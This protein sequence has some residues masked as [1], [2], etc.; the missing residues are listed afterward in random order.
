[1]PGRDAPTGSVPKAQGGAGPFQH[2]RRQPV[3]DGLSAPRTWPLQS[4]AQA[5]APGLTPPS[6]GCGIGAAV[7]PLPSGNGVRGARAESAPPLGKSPRSRHGAPLTSGGNG[8][9]GSRSSS[10]SSSGGGGGSAGSI[11]SQ[12]NCQS[13]STCPL[14]SGSAC[15]PVANFTGWCLFGAGRSG[16]GGGDADS[17]VEEWENTLTWAVVGIVLVSWEL[18]EGS[19][20]AIAKL[21]IDLWTG[22]GGVLKALGEFAADGGTCCAAMPLMRKL[23]GQP[24]KEASPIIMVFFIMGTLYFTYAICCVRLRG[25][26]LWTA[27]PIAFHV[28]F[29]LALAAYHQAIVIH[30]GRVPEGWRPVG[31][32]GTTEKKRSTGLPRYCNKEHVFKPD[33]AHYCTPLRCNV[34]RMDHFCPWMSTCIGYRNHKHFFLFLIYASTA[35]DIALSGTFAALVTA[36]VPGGAAIVMFEGACLALLLTGVLTPFLGLHCWLLSRNITTLEYCERMRNGEGIAVASAYDVGILANLRSVLGDSVWLW[37]LPIGSP[38]GDGC[39]WLGRDERAH[40][41]LL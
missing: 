23:L 14:V 3:P 19:A 27:G 16:E 38:P 13:A 29:V 20:C 35:A 28:T 37:P 34:L 39:T 6:G 22:A 41:D 32:V 8:S 9:S 15:D 33:R 11:S 4:H 12:G 5:A 25:G 1:M 7:G 10:S 21:A 40:D 31:G 30:P 2:Y 26:E 18:M 24:L 36:D 17:S